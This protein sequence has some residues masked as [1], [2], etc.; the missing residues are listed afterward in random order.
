MN[1]LDI[2]ILIPLLWGLYKGFTKG[3]II[4]LASLVA[5]FLAVWGG[6]NFS[7]SLTEYLRE[8]MGWSS[9]FL[10]I[11]SFSIIFLVILLLVYAIAKL[12]ELF[13]KTIALGF[14]NRL[15]GGIFGVLKYGLIISALIFI[16]NTIEKTIPLIPVEEKHNSLLYEPFEKITIFIFTSLN[17]SST[18]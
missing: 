17:S 18:N 5:L 10:P 12:T 2:I 16:M 1:Y 11:I 13:V 15:L 8:E 7:D 9:T 3:L 6:I 4:E 14:V